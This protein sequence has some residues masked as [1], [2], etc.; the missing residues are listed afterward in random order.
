MIQVLDPS[1]LYCDPSGWEPM[2]EVNKWAAMGT[3][4]LWCNNLI[5]SCTTHQTNVT[6]LQRAL[7]LKCTYAFCSFITCLPS[8]P[9]KTDTINVFQDI[10]NGTKPYLDNPRRHCGHVVPSLWLH[11]VAFG[12][13]AL[14]TGRLKLAKQQQVG[15]A[16]EITPPLVSHSATSHSHQTLLNTFYLFILGWN[17]CVWA[18]VSSNKR[19][20]KHTH[21]QCLD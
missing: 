10:H 15:S 14:W 20:H 17:E 21:W 19:L 4:L 1:D 11:N 6:L 3:I 9:T 18:P 7:A 8:F 5:P 13:W 12:P 16:G 2:T